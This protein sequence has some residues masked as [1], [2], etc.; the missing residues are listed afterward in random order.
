[1]EPYL[2]TKNL[3]IF[4][5]IKWGLFYTTSYLNDVMLEKK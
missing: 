5:R 3:M 2:Q 1:M 4:F